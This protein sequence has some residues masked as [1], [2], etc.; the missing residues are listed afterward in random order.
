MTSANDR[1]ELLARLAEGIADLT[2]SAS[3]QH[4]LDVQGRFHRY[5][6]KNAL[7]ITLQRQDATQV[8]GFNAWRKL[9]R[10]VRKGEKAIWV[11]APMMYKKENADNGDDDR[12]VRGFKFVPVFDVAQ[13][14][15]A[16]LPS[17]C[18]RITGEDTGGNFSKLL[19]VASSIGFR[20]EDHEFDGRTNGDCCHA[21]CRIRVEANNSPAQRVKTLAHEL[22]HALLHETFESRALAE[23][24]AE[25]IAYI[26]CN[27]LGID[28]GDYSFGYVATWAGGGKQAIAGIE[29]SCR[30]IQQTAT[31]VL[32]ACET[33]QA[34]RQAA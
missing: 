26:I 13:T 17:V 2:S 4:Y 22:A 11:L 14:E 25:S 5:S 24:E 15:G 20:V 33:P 21:E 19:R 9:D 30:R 6:F 34:S 27:G 23:M 29:A 28:S 18:R 1:P 10:T 8:A 16:D 3:W 31:T 32:N 7:L 12:V